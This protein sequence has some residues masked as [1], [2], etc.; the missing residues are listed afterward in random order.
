MTIPRTTNADALQLGNYWY[1]ALAHVELSRVAMG[2]EGE[3]VLQAAGLAS[4]IRRALPL[5]VDL[6]NFATGKDPNATYP[7]NES[8]WRGTASLAVTLAVIDEAPIPFA[9]H[10]GT[11]THA[12]ERR[13][14]SYP[15]A[16][17]FETMWDKQHDDFVEARGF[18]SRDAPK[19]QVGR[20][21]KIP[22]TLNAEILQL[23]GYWDA[24]WKKL[25]GRRGILGS[26]PT[27]Q[28]LD[29]QKTRW[30]AVMSDVTEIA[31]RGKVDEVY[32]KNHEFWREAHTLAVTLDLFKE[33][34]TKADIAIDVAKTLPD[35]FANVV[36]DIAN[37]LGDIAHK[38]AS[39]VTSGLGKPILIGGSVLLGGI[40]LWRWTRPK[41][42]EA[43]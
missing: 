10:P 32:S 38:A 3:H 40:L 13:N 37:A 16:G 18:D 14:A 22:R 20:T 33:L 25:E 4:E 31:G 26:L 17:T 29:G 19:G 24:A 35:R 41:R 36:S 8:L 28:G 12:I 15:G 1:H 27:E 23:A 30:E 34:P 2:P 39:G 5:F 21:M 7:K 43:A 42:T 11:A 9:M 6:D